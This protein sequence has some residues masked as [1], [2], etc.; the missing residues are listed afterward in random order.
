MADNSPILIGRDNSANPGAQTLLRRDANSTSTDPV[1][2]VRTPVGGDSIHGEASGG[3]GVQGTSNAVGVLGDVSSGSTG[4]GVRG[5]S[6]FGVGVWG[7]CDNSIGIFGTSDIYHGVSGLTNSGIGV[8]GSG[9]LTAGIGVQ[10]RSYT[11]TG[12]QGISDSGIG[13]E[14]YCASGFGV[15]GSSLNN[16]GVFGLADSTDAVHGMSGATGVQ[17]VSTAGG[18]GVRGDSTLFGVFGNTTGE[19]GI[20]VYGNSNSGVGVVGVSESNTAVFG[21][22]RNPDPVNRIVGGIFDGG[23]IATNGPKAFQIDHPLDPQNKYLMHTCVESSEMKNVYDGVARLDKD[24]T[25]S[26]ELPEWCEALNEDFC[27]QLT[28]V[29]GAAPNLHVAEEISENRFKIAGGKEGMKVCWQVTG[30]RK[31]AWAAANPV[32][33][34]E[35]KPQEERGRYL[36]PNL[37][38]E[39]EGRRVRRGPA[40]PTQTPRTPPS[41]EPPRVPEPPPSYVFC[42]EAELRQQ[43][44]DLRQQIEELR[45][46][47]KR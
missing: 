46:R 34:E 12:L 3:I 16:F 19:L 43:I 5:T 4:T 27:Y 9:S 8:V 30:T 45:R 24:G 15:K 44:D 23:I 21:V 38:N 10:G 39:P 2:T 22:C 47:R 32:E 35:E 11:T 14:G 40:E 26:V 13:V 7:D 36:H 17:G 18:S 31:D 37:Y 41:F 42:M 25:A 28:A 20:G 33:V 6:S 1:L 29:G